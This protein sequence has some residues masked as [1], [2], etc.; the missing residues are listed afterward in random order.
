MMSETD[1]AVRLRAWRARRRAQRRR[2][3]A[4]CGGVFTPNRSQARFC[5]SNCKQ[6]SFR[7]RKSGGRGPQ[8][9]QDGLS[10]SPGP[11]T[12]VV[13]PRPAL[14]PHGQRIDVASLIG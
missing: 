1:A 11:P 10:G 5:S 7:R 14:G 3:C 9:A 8:M 12:A 13:A 2:Y 4:D 6:R